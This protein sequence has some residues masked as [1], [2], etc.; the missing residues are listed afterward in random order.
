MFTIWRI[1]SRV[2]TCLSCV[3]A[4]AGPATIALIVLLRKAQ[5]HND[6]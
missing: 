2:L 4:Y 6:W 1:D 3:L 5:I